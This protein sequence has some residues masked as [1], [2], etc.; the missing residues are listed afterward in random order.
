MAPHFEQDTFRELRSLES[1]FDREKE[2]L[3]AQ[4][5]NRIKSRISWL[6]KALNNPTPRRRVV[7]LK[8]G[9]LTEAE[10]NGVAQIEDQDRK[11]RTLLEK[12]DVI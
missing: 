4:A 1:K 9:A 5:Y 3:S 12:H 10:R 2:D 7:G 11:L 8:R 6:R